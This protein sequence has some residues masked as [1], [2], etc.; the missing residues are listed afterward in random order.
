MAQRR[1][2]S[3]AVIA[4]AML[5][6]ALACSSSERPMEPP[7]AAQT[8]IAGGAQPAPIDTADAFSAVVRL[9]SP[10]IGVSPTGTLISC[11]EI[12]AGLNLYNKDAALAVDF[13]RYTN[14]SAQTV[15]TS[16]SLVTGVTYFPRA[17]MSVHA[18]T[19]SSKNIAV[20][21]LPAPPVKGIRPLPLFAASSSSSLPG[22]Q[23][24]LVGFGATAD[25]PGSCPVP[26]FGVLHDRRVGTILTAGIQLGTPTSPKASGLALLWQRTAPGEA[27][28]NLDDAGAP[29]LVGSPPTVAALFGWHPL[30]FTP[31]DRT[32]M[33]FTPIAE[34]RA[35]LNSVLLP[36]SRT[37]TT[38]A[39]RTRATLVRSV[40]MVTCART[41]HSMPER[42]RRARHAAAMMSTRTRTGSATM[43]TAARWSSRH[44]PST[45]TRSPRA[46]TRRPSS[47]RTFAIRFPR[48]RFRRWC[49]PSRCRTHLA[50][51]RSFAW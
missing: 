24:T 6:G 42:P 13:V 31:C 30:E 35:W 8:I 11:R 44:W 12:L 28:M 46:C 26:F 41:E 33:E 9:R 17:L 5:L 23:A 48:R 38:T 49:S 45:R 1:G 29:L 16:V 50:P 2:L 32:R 4:T 18:D 34:N 40:T 51:S 37:T 25:P 39:C 47:G 3:G 10:G 7:S 27:S 36:P 19:D 43:K 14:P 20:I 22:S 15:T 21:R